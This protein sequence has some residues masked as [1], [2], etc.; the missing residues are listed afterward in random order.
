MQSDR[1]TRRSDLPFG[2]EFSPSQI[3]LRAVLE[4]ADG[5][6]GDWR[7]FEQE[8]RATYFEGHQTSDYNKAKLANNTKL[9][10][11]A[12]GVIERDANLTEF[13][14]K[15]YEMRTDEEVL[16]GVLARRIC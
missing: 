6:G 2:S 7:A 11:I 1:R 14:R 5:N 13:G 15:L 8:M 12:Y 10:M 16:Y 4:I 3:D 9:G